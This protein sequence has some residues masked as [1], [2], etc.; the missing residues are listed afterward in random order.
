M[1]APQA[2]QENLKRL[3]ASAGMSIE[4]L[5]AASSVDR[6]TIRGILQGRR[7][8]HAQTLA[9]LTAALGVPADE[10]FV[11][12]ARLLCRR[13]DRQT[14]PAVEEAVADEPALFVDWTE[15]DFDE[16]HSHMGA[17]GPLTRDGV[18]AQAE[19]INRKRDLVGK[20]AL[21]LET[22]HAETVAGIIEVLYRQA[23][24]TPAAP[25]CEPETT[26]SVTAP[27]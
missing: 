5:S 3:L 27:G 24:V 13:F 17:G 19:R 12:P 10:L 18:L 8:P 22:S 4:Q 26:W 2:T 11:D 6:R 21:L 25:V 20:L 23:V 16:L 9:R 1:D 7:Q 14:N 15:A